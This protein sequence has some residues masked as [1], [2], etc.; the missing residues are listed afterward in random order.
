MEPNNCYDMVAIQDD[1]PVIVCSDDL[2]E[3]RRVTLYCC[4]SHI[5]CIG[6]TSE[7]W[8]K[9]INATK[10]NATFKRYPGAENSKIAQVYVNNTDYAIRYL[11]NITSSHIC[12][13]GSGYID[14]QKGI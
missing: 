13:K 8:Y 10:S 14:V 6:W 9:D 1:M 5:P 2:E 4:T 12:E 11:C 7:W 3:S